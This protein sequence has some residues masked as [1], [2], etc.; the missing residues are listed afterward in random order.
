MASTRLGYLAVRIEDTR[1]VAKKPTKYLRFKEGDVSYALE[2]IKNN[3]IQNTRW[4]AI[5]AVP[6]KVETNGS[7]KVD[8]DPNDIAFWLITALGNLSSSDISSL[9]DGSAYE[10]TI[11]SVCKVKSMT[12]EQGKGELCDDP[13]TKDGQ[14][15]SV[16][17]A[18]GAMIDSI[19]ISG[20]DSILE[21]EMEIKAHWVFQKGNLIENEDAEVASTVITGATWLAGIATFT[22]TSHGLAVNDLVNIAWMTPAWYNGA[23]KVLSTPTANTFT[24]AITVNPW[25]FSVGGTVVKLSMFRFDTV[26]GIVATDVVKMY[27]ATTGTYE[28]L[29]V[30]YVDTNRNVLGFTAVT[31]TIF[32]VANKT[33][34]EL[35]PQTPSYSTPEVMSFTHCK[36][37]FADTVANAYN[38]EPENVEDWELEFK[39]N[40]EERYGS[41]RRSASTIGEKG[42]E[43]MVKF[44][45][46]FETVVD[47]DRYLDQVKRSCVLTITNDAVIS[48]TDTNLN[49][50]EI[51]VEFSD[52]RFTTYEMPTGTD[53]LYAISAEATAFYDT[54]DGR[55]LRFKV[56]N[57]NAG[58]FYTG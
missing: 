19:K 52:I 2:I 34:V 56:K 49:K 51:N 4:N 38:A 11:N 24:V 55:A 50:Y 39:N 15:Y 25:A 6:W 27:E 57:K 3:P 33:K 9:T 7:Y 16:D 36:F 35:V 17:R 21:S 32:T 20:S 18:F 58:T 37:R 10:H 8:V 31:S 12:I 41:L 53:D 48:G 26:E 22:S 40:L 47:R 29:T 43:A 13:L 46:F 5:N 54:T 30:Q 14:T 44:S 28:N 42:A 45:K 23:Y 1:W